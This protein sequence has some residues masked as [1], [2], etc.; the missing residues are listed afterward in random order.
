MTGWIG[1]SLGD[2]TGIGPEVTLKALAAE[3]NADNTRHVIF[4]NEACLCRLSEQLRLHL[5]FRPYAGAQSQGRFF[6]CDSATEPL[7][8][9][10]SPGAPAAA[11]AAIGWLTEGAQRCLSKELD[12]LVTAP[13]NKESIIR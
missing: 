7:P 5:D 8:A 2:L 10:L 6:I 11:R 13:V 12:A 3:A 4:G 1:I 9:D